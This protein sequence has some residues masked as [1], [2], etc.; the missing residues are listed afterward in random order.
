MSEKKPSALF[1]STEVPI[2][3]VCG[4]PT[5]SAGGIHPQCAQIQAD[6]P[7]KQRLQEERKAEAAKK[8]KAPR[9]G[10]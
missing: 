1:G 9:K 4:Q 10:K 3:P 5:Y 7:R 8:G 6:A 2:C